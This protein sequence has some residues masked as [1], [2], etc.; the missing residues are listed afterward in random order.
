MI[1]AISLSLISVLFTFLIQ[2]KEKVS[3]SFLLTFALAL[4]GLGYVLTSF[5]I[6]KNTLTVMI[7]I[8]YTLIISSVKDCRIQIVHI[9]MPFIFILESPSLILLG[10]LSVLSVEQE[11]TKTSLLLIALSCLGFFFVELVPNSSQVLTLALLLLIFALI[12]NIR[13]RGSSLI[14][15]GTFLSFTKL[16]LIYSTAGWLCAGVGLIF[17]SSI[18][19]FKRFQDGS[20]VID[21]LK[22]LILSAF[23]A[24]VFERE[25]TILFYFLVLYWDI[26][27]ENKKVSLRKLDLTNVNKTR[28]FIVISALFVTYVFVNMQLPY[29]VSGVMLSMLFVGV[30]TIE[31]FKRQKV[32]FLEPIHVFIMMI[33]FGVFY[34]F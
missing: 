26:L 32:N 5:P 10:L 27:S 12:N 20:V 24:G 15:I 8:F 21:A 7:V 9:W 25:I 1:E 2:K 16:T 17:I 34:D 22:C 4:S 11:I 3:F 31:S 19:S 23:L 6:E 28:V 18:L 14:T 13:S 29:L 30:F 33:S